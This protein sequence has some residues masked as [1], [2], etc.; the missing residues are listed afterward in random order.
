MRANGPTLAVGGVKMTLA[1]QIGHQIPF[2]LDVPTAKNVQD[3][4][5]GPK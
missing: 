1:Q 5:T 2:I 3:L 4:E